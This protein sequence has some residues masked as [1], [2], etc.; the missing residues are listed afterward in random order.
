M[1][2]VKG[3]THTLPDRLSRYPVKDNHCPDLED[4]FV[5]N[6]ASKSLRTKESGNTPQDPHVAKI[7]E[8]GKGPITTVKEGSEL[9]KIQCQF[10]NLS[11]FE[12][13]KGEVIIRDSTDILVP[14]EYRKTLLD[15][16]H[17]THMSDLSI[18]NFARGHFYWPSLK[19][20][21][22]IVE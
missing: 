22:N 12:T 18:M 16:L 19:N 5:P 21:S 9:K 2:H 15:E 1:V 6:I 20:D 3:A 8:V 11:L 17:S 14:K 7:V 10:N 13:D 4:H